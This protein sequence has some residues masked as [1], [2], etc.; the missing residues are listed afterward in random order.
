[1]QKSIEKSLSSNT[2]LV[3]PDLQNIT[4]HIQD[5]PQPH[6]PVEQHILRESENVEEKI[7]TNIQLEQEQQEL[8]KLQQHHHQLQLLQQQET[9]R[10]QQMQLLQQEQQQIELIQLLQQQQQQQEQMQQIQQLLMKQQH[11]QQIL[12]QQQ[13]QNQE[14]PP[15]IT[16]SPTK[17]APPR[18]MSPPKS[19]QYKQVPSRYMSPPKSRPPPPQPQKQPSPT[20]AKIQSPIKQNNRPKQNIPQNN[21]PKSP[22]KPKPNIETQQ[23]NNNPYPYPV[24]ENYQP[25]IPFNNQNQHITANAAQFSNS[26]YP[27]FYSQY[28]PQPTPIHPSAMSSIP[29]NPAYP[30]STKQT[31]QVVSLL[32]NAYYDDSDEEDNS[33]PVPQFN[34]QSY[35]SPEELDEVNSG[36]ELEMDSK[37]MEMWGEIK[38]EYLQNNNIA[39]QQQMNP[40]SSVPTVRGGSQKQGITPPRSQVRAVKKL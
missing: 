37:E 13:L 32:D 10:Q 2:L 21:K 29:S 18:Y 6:V 26:T 3:P 25:T 12:L 4:Q 34:S 38:R 28:S 33:L 35:F 5:N 40:R 17:T 30:P 8:L 14:L 23:F 20:K 15:T 16:K 27:G 11:I 31:R 22:I 19:Q 1:M 24:E 36:I 9:I 7:E 39:V